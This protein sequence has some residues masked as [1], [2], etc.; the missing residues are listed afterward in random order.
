MTRKKPPLAFVDRLRNSPDSD[1]KIHMVDYIFVDSRLWTRL[2]RP[3]CS[4]TCSR[5]KR[6]FSKSVLRKGAFSA[7]S[8]QVSLRGYLSLLWPSSCNLQT[9]TNIR[10]L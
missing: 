1:P 2:F 8:K 6:Q 4:T 3:R 10:V 5:A 9:T 7:L